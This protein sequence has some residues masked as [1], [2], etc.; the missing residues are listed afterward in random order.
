MSKR[1]RDREAVLPP[2]VELRAHAHNERHR[3]HSKLHEVVNLVS[4]GVEPDDVIEPGP[5]WKPVH[6]HDAKVAQEMSRRVR[7]RHWKTKD[8]KRRST[9]RKQRALEIDHLRR[10]A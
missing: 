9:Q 10:S 6:H 5:N 7:L 4:H 8:W 1:H 2:T 3:V